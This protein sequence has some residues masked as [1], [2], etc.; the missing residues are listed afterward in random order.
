MHLGDQ[1]LRHRALGRLQ[2]QK[3]AVGESLGQMPRDGD[4]IG[5]KPT[6]RCLERWHAAQTGGE[7][8]QII[9]EGRAVEDIRLHPDRDVEGRKG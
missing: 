4:G 9:S 1:A 3:P 6:L 2:W 5:Q 7:G 8:R